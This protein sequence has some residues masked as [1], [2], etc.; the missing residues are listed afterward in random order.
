MK[1][2]KPSLLFSALAL[3]FSLILLLQPVIALEWWQELA[4]AEGLTI[5]EGYMLG[6]PVSW[7]IFLGNLIYVH[8][9]NEFVESK[10]AATGI[11]GDSYAQ[12]I[13]DKDKNFLEIY[14]DSF[15]LLAYS[16]K[17]WELYFVRRAEYTSL[18]YLSNET[19]PEEAMVNVVQD[20]RRLIVRI[21]DQ[22]NYFFD[23]LM[24]DQNN[25]FPEG[26]R[27]MVSSSYPP[28][29]SFAGIDPL[30][31]D[32]LFR[33]VLDSPSTNDTI[34]WDLENL[35]PVKIPGVT[36]FDAEKY[37]VI[38]PGHFVIMFYDDNNDLIYK[39]RYVILF[40]PDPNSPPLD[41]ID[42]Q[43]LM[44]VITD[45]YDV[46]RQH[47]TTAKSY[48]M[49]YWSW[50]RSLGYTSR[51][52]VPDTYTCPPPS[53]LFMDLSNVEKITGKDLAYLYSSWYARLA[54]E[55]TPTGEVK[56]CMSIA[57]EGIQSG[58]LTVTYTYTTESTYTTTTTT[59]VNATTTTY[60]TVINGTTTTI[61]TTVG[62]TT[63]TGVITVTETITTT[64]T[65]TPEDVE[66]PDVFTR[67]YNVTICIPDENGT[68]SCFE[69][70]EM[71]I[72]DSLCDVSIRV[73]EP[74]TLS[75]TVTVMVDRDGSGMID[76]L[77][78]PAGTQI[79]VGSIRVKTAEGEQ[80]L[81][82]YDYLVYKIE[83]LLKKYHYTHEP[84]TVTVT[85]GI[86]QGLAG[87][88]V[89][90]STLLVL[91]PMFIFLIVFLM[92]PKILSD[93]V[94]ASRHRKLE[95]IG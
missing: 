76:F 35:K 48:A 31:D 66:I 50:L 19:F 14:R 7:A 38:A 3:V 41:Y 84:T 73:G 49:T 45:F 92:I 6:T 81:D 68:M 56:S 90:W 59:V 18:N 47:Y 58:N 54:K 89:L 46:L 36:V 15:N 55:L 53:A 60:T 72:I 95:V 9:L 43:S 74:T 79:T 34:I 8:N 78:L 29:G 61:T 77:T 10:S 33:Y 20:M 30:E 80:E 51:D 24:I 94:K 70:Y 25:R 82:S 63:Q 64:T 69:V 27:Y 83:E 23:E 5:A 11:T 91:F 4:L 42:L 88:G 1:P 21:R 39:L 62:G 75:C 12:A 17:L 26:Y 87:L 67:F 85:E 16:S 28:G 86:D 2:H 71:V 44:D 52:Q 32:I 40:P 57:L 65:W 22:L 93:I 13:F 37:L